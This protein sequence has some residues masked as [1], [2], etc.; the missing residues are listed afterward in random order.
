MFVVKH[1]HTFT[2]HCVAANQS[3]PLDVGDREK[4]LLW[5]FRGNRHKVGHLKVMLT[6]P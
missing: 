5:Y 2:V 6:F 1:T 3:T 4:L